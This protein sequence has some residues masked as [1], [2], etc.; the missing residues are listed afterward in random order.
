MPELQVSLVERSCETCHTSESVILHHRDGNVADN[1]VEN[2]Q[3]LC[4]SCHRKLH[5]QTGLR[6]HRNGLPPDGENIVQVG[7]R[8]DRILKARLDAEAARRNVSASTIVEDCIRLMQETTKNGR[9]PLPSKRMPE[10]ERGR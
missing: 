5:L 6:R 9:D 1:R 4:R 2:L 8:I 7:W 10:A 3:P